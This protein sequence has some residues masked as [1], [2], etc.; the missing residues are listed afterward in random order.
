MFCQ[1]R[2]RRSGGNR[3]QL[4]ND[5]RPA[6]IKMSPL[7]EGLDRALV[8]LPSVAQ[9]DA[10]MVERVSARHR[11]SRRAYFGVCKRKRLLRSNEFANLIRGWRSQ[12]EHINLEQMAS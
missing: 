10:I 6:E 4:R 5:L 3:G 2:H 11:F 9:L 12:E 7:P 1:H 8:G